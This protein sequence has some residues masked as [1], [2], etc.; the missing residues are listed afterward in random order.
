MR[1]VP[2]KFVMAGSLG[3]FALVLAL[4]LAWVVG[5]QA[6]ASLEAQIERTLANAA[7]LM[8]DRL[9]RAMHERW[10]EVRQLSASPV[11]RD[12][13]SGADAK[14]AALTALK[15]DTPHYAWL[16][17]IEASG[18]VVA[19]TDGLFE[20]GDARVRAWFHEALK[21]PFL[22]D[23]HEAVVLSR[24]LPAP[25]GE[26][27]RFVD[28]AFPVRD[29]AGRVLGVVGAHVNWT[30]ARELEGELRGLAG[31]AAATEVLVLSRDGTVWLGPPE[32]FEKPFP[33][34][35]A[36]PREAGVPPR[37]IAADGTHLT[38]AVRTT[39]YRDY[40][41]L[42]WVVVARQR[43]AEALAPVHDLQRQVAL[44]GLGTAALV[45]GLAL[46]AGALVGRRLTTL[47]AAAE[48][49]ELLLQETN[50]R[51]KNA[52]QLVA[53]LLQMQARQVREGEARDAFRLAADRVWAV[54]QVHEQLYRAGDRLSAVE[55]GGLL[56]ALSADLQ[57]SGVL[58]GCELR[59]EAD[60]VRLQPDQTLPLGLIV[61]ELLTNAAKYGQPPEGSGRAPRVTLMLKDLGNELVLRV[62]DNGPGLPADALGQ[63][64]GL[65]ARIMRALSAQLGG[66]LEI[67][68]NPDGPGA[69]VSL[70]FPPRLRPAGAEVVDLR[71]ARAG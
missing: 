57:A 67:A 18:R 6:S 13:S 56:A 52:L 19:A 50:H 9:D 68:G 4:L 47:S 53:N 65:G 10:R 24:F 7:V 48:Q 8:R 31:S 3:A 2:F 22:G 46:W 33:L 60:P 20:G 11:L 28:V 38:A 29:E 14:R 15:L 16:G 63:G 49:T 36:L 41:G 54:G 42:G 37:S 43:A 35:G 66:R 12:P 55:A 23:V 45:T 39:G 61:N 71:R 44:W 30:F 58:E 64:T 69:A 32:L 70:Y 1:G 40:P 17:F 5:R 34:A 59:V 51:V 27:L 21:G 25:A 62:T 26:P